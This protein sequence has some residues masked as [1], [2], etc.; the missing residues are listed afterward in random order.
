LSRFGKIGTKPFA[1][2]DGSSVTAVY[3]RQGD[4]I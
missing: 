1:V 3:D 2:Y 4:C